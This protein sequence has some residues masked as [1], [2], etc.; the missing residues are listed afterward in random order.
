MRRG[1][2]FLV[3][4]VLA[5][6]LFSCS[7]PDV[8]M[9]YRHEYCELALNLPTSYTEGKSDSFDVIFTNGEAVVGIQRLSF[10]GVEND[11]LDGSM[12]P[13]KV[14]RKY[15]EKNALEVEITDKEDHSY[16]TYTDGAYYNLIAF[17]RSKYAHFIVRF[18]CIEEKEN[19][20][21]ADFLRFSSEAKFTQ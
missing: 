16:F 1:I 7:E 10:Q 13:E 2:A 17:Y 8:D 3:S 12:F 14:A 18:M 15:A 5:I 11:D 21:S 20:Y 4:L 9:T 6:S 19:I